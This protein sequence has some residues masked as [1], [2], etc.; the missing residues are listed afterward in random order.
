M[1]FFAGL[2]HY[3]SGPGQSYSVAAFKEAMR[4]SLQISETAYSTAYA[5]AT[6]VSGMLLPLV[7]R[8]LDRW[9]ARVMLP[10]IGACLGVACV[11]MSGVTG[12]VSLLIGFSLVR[13]SGQ[14]ALTLAG[15]WLAGEWYETRRGWATAL[16]G[17]GGSVSVM[18]LPLLN[19]YVILA[20]DWQS[21]WLVLGVLVATTLVVPPLLFVR[22]RPEDCGWLPDGRGAFAGDPTTIRHH[23]RQR[24]NWSAIAEVLKDPTFWKL[25]AVP[26][27]SGLV[28]TGLVFHQVSVM[29][30][31]GISSTWAIS[32]L[33][34]QATIATVM[35]LPAGWLTDRL[36]ARWILATAMGL[37]ALAVT[38]LWLQLPFGFLFVYAACMGIHG[39]IIRSAGMV[40]WMTYYG[41]ENQGTIRGIALSAMIFAAAVGPVP[42]ALSVDWFGSYQHCLALYLLMPLTAGL[43][44]AG[45]RPPRDS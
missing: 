29:S 23:R 6:V 11:L 7:G 1:V 36:A 28:G 15:N 9:G 22:N 17:M 2:A 5:I 8:S 41:R 24:A 42:M 27:T 35:A 40:V 45:A 33:S 44:V 14:G 16:A 26:I 43:V 25:L 37:L 32:L 20:A 19:N 38:L 39:S 18:T 4:E 3:M 34:I 13:S 21:A 31:R 12:F 30:E 10:L